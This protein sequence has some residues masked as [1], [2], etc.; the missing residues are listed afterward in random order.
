MRRRH[1]EHGRHIQ[2]AGPLQAA[3]VRQEVEHRRR[4]CRRCRGRR[5]RRKVG[6][7]PAA[8]GGGGQH[9]PDDDGGRNVQEEEGQAAQEQG[10]GGESIAVYIRLQICSFCS[11]VAL[12]LN[13]NLFLKEILNAVS[14][15]SE[16]V[17]T[18][19]YE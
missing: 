15:L 18:N 6:V 13:R 19:F 11:I 10:R 14:H 4:R 16:H 1:I 7:W 5:I 12:C 9:D 8:G 2:E 17:Q 3:R